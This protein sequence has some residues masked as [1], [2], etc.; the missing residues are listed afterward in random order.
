MNAGVRRCRLGG[1]DDDA[2]A[3][4]AD[5]HDAVLATHDAD[6]TRRRRR[7]T[8]GRHVFLGCHQLEAVE[9]LELHIEE[10]VGQVGAPQHRCL[11]GQADSDR[12]SPSSLRNRLSVLHGRATDG[13]TVSFGP[14]LDR[15]RMTND[16]K[17]RERVRGDNPRGTR[18]S[19]ESAVMPGPPDS[20]YGSKDWGF[21]SLRAYR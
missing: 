14:H 2:V 9:L 12:V 17:R 16:P 11:R 13:P 15:G 5:D 19:T 21:E 4:Y 10:L 7:F 6:A 18:V 1:A 8:F 20:D 3:I